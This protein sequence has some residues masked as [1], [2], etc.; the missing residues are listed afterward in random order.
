MS[1]MP[2]TRWLVILSLLA[3]IASGCS[4]RR[5][6]EKTLARTNHALLREEA[7]VLYKQTFA[8]TAPSFSAIKPDDWPATF[9]AFTPRHVG[10]FKDGFSLALK[11]EG[12]VESGL[13]IVP[14][15]MD[16]KPNPG[17]RAKF[18]KLGDGIY[19]YSFEP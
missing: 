1:P 17:R 12:G 13:Y 19:W 2:L 7:A 15:F 9:R 10:A 8:G 14:K 5:K 3:F 18:E 11:L 6:A 16:V 4:V